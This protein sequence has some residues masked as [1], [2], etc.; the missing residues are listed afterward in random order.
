LGKLIETCFRLRTALRGSGVSTLRA[1]WSA[2]IDTP[3]GTSIGT[4]T[5]PGFNDWTIAASCGGSYA[6]RTQPKSPPTAAV[7]AS[8]YCRA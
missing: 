6:G 4:L 5:C 7:D 8:E 1:S 3:P 2:M